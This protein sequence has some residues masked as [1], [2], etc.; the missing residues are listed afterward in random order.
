MKIEDIIFW[1]FLV[2]AIIFFL[3][4]LF[5]RSPSIEQTLLVLVIGLVV[6]LHGDIREIKGDYR[7]FKEN[8]KLSFK[9]IRKE[10][11]LIK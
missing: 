7:Q 10:R 6:K 1:I 8:V 3:W 4:F 5:G 9:N 11:R 2:I